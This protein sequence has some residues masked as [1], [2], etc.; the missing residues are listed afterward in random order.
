MICRE[1][2][3]AEC[4]GSEKSNS[5]TLFWVLRDFSLDMRDRE[6]NPLTADQ[7][8]EQS[9]STGTTCNGNVNKQS[10]EIIQNTFPSRNCVALVRP[11]I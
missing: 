5:A 2:Q 7:Y 4:E 9:L 1:A 10:R 8:L 6:N 11:T 3:L